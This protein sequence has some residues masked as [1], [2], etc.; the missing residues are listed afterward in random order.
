MRHTN[1]Q[2]VVGREGRDTGRESIMV[3]SKMAGSS[4]KKI[5]DFNSFSYVICTSRLIG[6]Y[7]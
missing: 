6:S 5:E 3:P 7:T 2:N 1:E 4:N